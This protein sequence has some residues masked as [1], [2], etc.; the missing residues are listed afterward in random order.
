VRLGLRALGIILLLGAVLLGA[1][2]RASKQAVGTD[3]HV[4]WQGGYDFAHGLSVYDPQPGARRFNYPPFAAQVFQV[5]GI[6]PLPVAA[7][8]FYVASAG[9]IVWAVRLLHDIVHELDPGK[10]QSLL[11]L[12]LAVAFSA[13]FMLDNLVHVQV[14]LLIFVLCLLG[15][16][17]FVERRQFAAG[18]W[19]TVATAIKV[20]PVFFVVWA[21]LRGTRRTL[22]AVAVF[23]A[24]C[25]SLPVLQRG[26]EQGV[27]D[28]SAYYQN[29]LH[30]FATGKVVADYRNQNLAA[31]VYRA[32]VPSAAED[33]PPYEYAYLSS[34][35]AAAPAIYRGAAVLVLVAFLTYLLRRRIAGEPVSPLEISSVF[36]TGHL[37]SGITWKAHLVTFLFVAYAFFALK[38]KLMQGRRRWVLWL[39]WAGIVVIG[40]GRDIVGSRLHHYM[41]GYS[42]YVWVML[43]LFTLSLAWGRE[44]ASRLF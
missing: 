33:E 27:T 12:I 21:L 44:K 35:A 17:A 39:S 2:E 23:A 16:Q 9:L 25:L 36:L 43:L 1:T 4:Y 14:N 20:T 24:V 10:R 28:L 8:L 13:V 19:L 3:F 42:V 26:P 15:I 29:F 5:L 32:F 31:M 30:Q 40:L 11:P 6:I 38:P 22:A 34:H 18:G 37:L 41:A 7:W